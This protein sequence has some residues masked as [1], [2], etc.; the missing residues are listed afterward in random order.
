MP[1]GGGSRGGGLA[2][3]EGQEADLGVGQEEGQG[4]V[5]QGDG[6]GGKGGQRPWSPGI[7]G[8]LRA[9]GLWRVVRRKASGRQV[10]VKVQARWRS[11][12]R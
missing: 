8:G 7:P 3:E 11:K 2:E 6:P 4:E 10:A 12:R 5:G 1:G 9:G